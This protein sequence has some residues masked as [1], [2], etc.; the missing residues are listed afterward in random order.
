MTAASEDVEQQAA[1]RLIQI[2]ANGSPNEWA[3]LDTWL[4]RHPRNRAVFLRLS[5]AWSRADRLAALRCATSAID[6]N[7]LSRSARGLQ[8]LKGALARRHLV[9]AAA[10]VALV[11]AALPHF[12]GHDSTAAQAHETATGERAAFALTDGS[13]VALNTGSRLLVRYGVRERELHL[14]RGEAALEV[15]AD[16]RRPFVVHAGSCIFRVL[17]TAFSVRVYPDGH[18]EI[19]VTEGRIAIDSDGVLAAG[20]TATIRGGTVLKRKVSLELLAQKLAWTHGRLF[21]DGETLSAAAR[22]FNRYNRVQLE[23]ADRELATLRIFGTFEADDPHMFVAALEE[24]FGIR[25]AAAPD[26]KGGRVIRL[27]RRAT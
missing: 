27:A 14:V 2:D 7:A 24:P 26:G 13:Q 6:E 10:I 25:P 11:S 18:V 8:A 20:E 17:G 21:F 15:R 4:S 22:E 19:A 5:L 16:A 9:T 3:C 12:F 23:V 1:R